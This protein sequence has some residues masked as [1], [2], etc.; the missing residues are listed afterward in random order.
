MRAAAVDA[1]V[2]GGGIAGA[3]LALL[4]ARRGA[5]VVLADHGR[6]HRSGPYETL[7]GS[8]RPLLDRLALT[9][10]LD[11][12]AARDPLRHGACWGSDELV[13]REPGEP[14]WLLARGAADAG[15]R[16]T[17]AAAGATVAEATRVDELADGC[18][19]LRGPT[20]ERLL[21]PRT[22][23]S[24]SGRTGRR[25]LQWRG[26]RTFACTMVG[27]VPE[28]DRGT[29]VVEAVADGWI[30][31]HAPAHG[32]ASAAVLLDADACHRDGHHELTRRALQQARGPAARLCDAHLAN[33]TDA[34]AAS[35][36]AAPDR[37]RLGDAAASIDPLA[38]Q[39]VEKALA[40]ADQAAAAVATA[41]IRPEWW[42]QLCAQ[43]AQ[44]ERDL[45]LAHDAV[46]AQWY[47]R[48]Q[49]F[50]GAP[51]WRA[52]QQRPVPALDPQRPL[53][54]AT[55]LVPA[56]VLVRQADAF[57]AQDGIEHRGTGDRLSQL[58]FVPVAPLLRAFATPLSLAAGVAAAGREPRLFVLPPR[59]VWQAAQRLLQRGWL[60]PAS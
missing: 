21:R 54:V 33:V 38:S 3:S 8:A 7:L 44:W 12:I 2:V 18:F 37:L 1:L 20:G 15:L 6:L 25:A 40:A 57:V 56:M 9:A 55:A 58:G 17:A 53:Q 4:L 32:P 13:W 26:P 35:V 51:F 27:T 50:A 31:T 42:P 16:A 46:A 49:R 43:H 36:A 59:A 47:A 24:A 39:G 10:V 28:A 48:E 30:W 5:T 19:R 11:R 60:V 14:G 45:A 23:I 52:R 22:V 29:A 34:T 41:L